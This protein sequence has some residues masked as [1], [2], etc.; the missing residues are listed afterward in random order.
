MDEFSFIIEQFNNK[1][2]FRNVAPGINQIVAPYFH[3]DGDMME[4]YVQPSPFQ[5]DYI[6]VTDLGMTLMRLSYSIDV[7]GVSA[8]KHIHSIINEQ[9]LA[10]DNGIVYLDT[11]IKSAHSYISYFAQGL[12]KIMAVSAL[13]KDVI[14]SYF[15]ENFRKFIVEDF[16]IYS[17]IF[18]YIPVKAHDEYT[19]D[20]MFMD[21]RAT[22]PICLFPVKDTYKAR[23]VVSTILFLQ[24]NKIPHRSVVVY[25]DFNNIGDK[26]KRRI[27][28][29][30]DK[31]FYTF[32]DFHDEGQ[33][34]MGKEVAG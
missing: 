16:I 1:V 26:D 29:A 24:N 10:Y 23:D 20:Y 14:K 8:Q 13:S 21:S 34:Y 25:E 17:P 22:R 28:N 31:N 33:K 9:R 30:S 27:M 4:I 18:N 7:D 19:V 3:A 11:P 32:G 12:S 5:H 2:S 6:R 15:Y